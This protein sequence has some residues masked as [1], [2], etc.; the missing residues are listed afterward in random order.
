LDVCYLIGGLSSCAVAP[1]RLK[2]SG[3]KSFLVSLIPLAEREQPFP[4]DYT[5]SQKRAGGM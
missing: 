4:P 1:I 5:L 3:W 2:I